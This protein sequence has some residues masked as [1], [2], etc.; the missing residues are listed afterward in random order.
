MH[1]VTLR[2][3]HRP[4]PFT[5]ILKNLY[6]DAAAAGVDCVDVVSGAS[7]LAGWGLCLAVWV[8]VVWMSCQVL[9]GWLVGGCVWQCGCLL[10]G[11]RVRC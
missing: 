8:F 10:C 5:V 7:W 2:K 3:K 6:R 4:S 1:R 9:A 11:C